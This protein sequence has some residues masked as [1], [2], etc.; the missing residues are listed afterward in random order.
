M[1]DQ[2]LIE[3]LRQFSQCLENPDPERNPLGEIEDLGEEAVPR[4][5]EVLEHGEAQIRRMVICVL[6]CLHSPHGGPFDL[7]PAIP[8]LE[9]ALQTDSDSL[10]R[11]YAA[12]ALWTIRGDK[13][14]VRVF[15]GGLHE[16][17]AAARRYAATMLGMIGPE[18]QESLQPLID[19][20]DDTDV[21]V[22]RCATEDLAAFGPTAIEAL[23]KLE[24][25]L[26][27]DEWTRL[28]VAE[29]IVKI[30]RAR[31][32]EMC[33]VLVE[34][35]QSGSPR[36]RHRATQ[37]LA[38]LPDA[39]SLAVAALMEA[40]DDEEE[41]VRTGAMWA[42]EQLGPAA[43]S[44]IP[45]LIA[46]LQGHGMDGDDILIRGMAASA[47]A[48][49]GFEARQAAPDL[50]ECL[51]EPDNGLLATRFRLQ[52]ARA[53]WKIQQEPSYLVSIGIEALGD[54]KWSLRR[55]AAQWL[56]DVGPV[57]IAASPH[58]R[59]ALRD[60]HP[61]VRRQAA[62]SLKAIVGDAPQTGDQ[63]LD[64]RHRIETH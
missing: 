5:V 7:G 18:A 3:L 30:D 38:E 54:P 24:A 1:D 50:L 43:S 8:R 64:H 39:G 63:S 9:V 57:G 16:G 52:V 31:T 42:L 37:A 33:P 13:A 4:L 40:L 19:A 6:G 61:V 62:A 35:L 15:V 17:E 56:G 28:V 44:A 46:I 12:E 49:I 27:E 58:L 41:L 55:L 10:V 21:V 45:P 23:P 47:L 29:A 2:R 20:L 59:G 14:A 60:S 11:L 36:I 48:E 34:G 51:H 53:L 32:E 26:D 22:R 25:L